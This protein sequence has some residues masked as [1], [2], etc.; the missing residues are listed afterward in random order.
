MASS[1]KGKEPSSIT[2]SPPAWEFSPITLADK[3]LHQSTPHLPAPG[4]FVIKPN[5]TFP[6]GI[7]AAAGRAGFPGKRESSWVFR[8]G[9]FEKQENGSQKRAICLHAGQ[10]GCKGVTYDMTNHLSTST[11]ILHT[12]RFHANSIKDPE[13][14]KKLDEKKGTGPSQM[15]LVDMQT[16]PK[17]KREVIPVFKDDAY[18]AAV[19]NWVVASDQPLSEPSNWWFLQMM[20]VACPEAPRI[21]AD[22][23]RGDILDKMERLDGILYKLLERHSFAAVTGHWVGRDW[24]MKKVLLDFIHV[25]GQHSGDNLAS[26]I[27]EAL[28]KRGLTSK[29]FDSEDSL[30]WCFAHILHLA[31]RAGLAKLRLLEFEEEDVTGGNGGPVEKTRK[32]YASQFSDPSKAR[33]LV[34]PEGGRE[35]SASDRSLRELKLSEDEWNYLEK[36]RKLLD[37]MAQ[38]LSIVEGVVYPTLV[39]VVPLFNIIMD[40]L[41]DKDLDSEPLLVAVRASIMDVL[42]KYYAKTDDS[43]LYWIAL[44]EYSPLRIQLFSS[45]KLINVE[46]L[47]P[48]YKLSW[49]REQ[50]WES[51]YV[52][53]ADN[54]VRTVYQ[55]GYSDA[56]SDMGRVRGERM[57]RDLLLS[58]LFDDDEEMVGELDRYLG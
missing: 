15:T 39:M 28:R 51:V 54:A 11:L 20:A 22:M 24:T 3:G 56:G 21:S 10:N 6:S 7:H 58:N 32:L 30:V 13:T 18:R 38:A 31:V 52:R 8:D 12:I 19:L 34:A 4:A 49:M 2:I 5:K 27:L 17:R 37:P 47:H 26:I 35:A 1:Y 45:E 16:A 36:V 48:A 40:R 33:E 44:G 14:R 57:S 9:H 55:A 29:D 46:V 53:Q 41:V 50:Q 42:Q 25:K 23:I 43:K